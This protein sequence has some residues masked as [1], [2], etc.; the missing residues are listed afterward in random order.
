MWWLK[1]QAQ[2]ARPSYCG[3]IFE[4]T[5]SEPEIFYFLHP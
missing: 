5:V 1:I 3:V 2:T 4:T